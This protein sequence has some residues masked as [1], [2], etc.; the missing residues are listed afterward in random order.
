MKTPQTFQEWENEAI[1]TTL[2]GQPI[3]R[4]HSY[5][6]MY[7]AAAELGWNAAMKA[8]FVQMCKCG[9]RAASLCD[10]E[11]GLNCDLGNNLKF[12]KISNLKPL[13]NLIKEPPDVKAALKAA[14]EALYFDDNSDFQTALWQV[15]KALDKDLA[16]KLEHQPKAAY[17]AVQEE[18][19]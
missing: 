9:D 16:Y 10:E 19:K 13:F 12:V 17:N 7:L 11:W 4:K 3:T 2:N 5:P 1:D 15:V 6:S 14:V 18:K 8:K